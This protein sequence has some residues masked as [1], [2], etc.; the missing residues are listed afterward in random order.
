MLPCSTQQYLQKRFS[1]CVVSGSDEVTKWMDAVRAGA[2]A[3][4]VWCCADMSAYV[5]RARQ[6]S[7]LVHDPHL[8]CGRNM[9]SA[10]DHEGPNGSCS[11]ARDRPEVRQRG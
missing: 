7:C 6:V 2:S 3:R 1:H 8:T 5:H 11:D 10:P 9:P 4:R